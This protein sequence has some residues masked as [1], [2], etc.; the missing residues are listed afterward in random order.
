MKLMQYAH[1]D[2][3]IEQVGP[4]TSDGTPRRRIELARGEITG[5]AHV[6]TGDLRV[7]GAIINAIN[8]A[9]VDH[10]EHG[11]IDLPPGAYTVTRQ[12]EWRGWR[13]ARV[14]D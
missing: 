12:R 14:Q 3:L 7:S 1:G 11:V 13:A 4:A 5:H 8:G 6:L 2:L 10:P 9:R